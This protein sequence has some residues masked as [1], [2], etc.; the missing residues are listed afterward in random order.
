MRT[1][2]VCRKEHKKRRFSGE[3]ACKGFV[4]GGLVMRVIWKLKLSIVYV[5]SM[6]QVQY[7]IFGCWRAH[8]LGKGDN[9]GNYK[10]YVFI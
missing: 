1:R 4:Q 5:S 8:V 10:K 2:K 3:N 6:P 7:L 9:I